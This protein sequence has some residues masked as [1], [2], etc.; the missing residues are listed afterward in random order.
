MTLK[1]L[2]RLEEALPEINKS[3]KSGGVKED[4]DLLTKKVEEWGYYAHGLMGAL[5]LRGAS[6]QLR[7]SLPVSSG[8]AD[9]RLRSLQDCLGELQAV[10]DGFAKAIG[11]RAEGLV[12]RFFKDE[13]IAHKG[14]FLDQVKRFECEFQALRQEM[15]DTLQGLQ[16]GLR[17]MDVLEQKGV[18]MLVTL[19][20]N[21][22]VAKLEQIEEGDEA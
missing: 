4:A 20:P 15:G 7:C 17:E 5:R 6:T 11:T 3:W 8:P 21:G 16:F 19:D 1:K 9:H 22:E 13:S 2:E 10:Q 14:N 18:A 12:S